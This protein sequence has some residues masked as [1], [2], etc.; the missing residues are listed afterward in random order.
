MVEAAGRVGVLTDRTRDEQ[1][2]V[3]YTDTQAAEFD[4][5]WCVRQSVVQESIGWYGFG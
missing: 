4:D 2:T 3:E 5:E 1:N